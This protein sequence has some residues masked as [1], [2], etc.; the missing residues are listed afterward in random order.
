[1]HVCPYC[2]KL[3]KEN[4]KCP[5]C[6][7]D[8]EDPFRIGKIDPKIYDIIINKFIQGKS[9]LVKIEASIPAPDGKP[10]NYPVNVLANYLN[11]IIKIKNLTE[12]VGVSVINDILYLE[13]LKE[14]EQEDDVA[15]RR[16]STRVRQEVW[17]R[18]SGKCVRCGSRKNLEYDHVIPVSEGGS[19]TAR[20][21][22]LLCE[23][24]NRK[25]Q[26][27]SNKLRTRVYSFI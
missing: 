16:I 14:I 23:E 13:R 27:I 1:M 22:E 15:S 6:G 8:P 3:F 26:I 24:C 10:L 9:K 19:N 18:D 21:I 2:N 12:E 17:R 5:K 25:R 11:E 20:N 4:E 7:F